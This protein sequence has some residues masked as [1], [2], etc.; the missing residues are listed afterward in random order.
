M[1]DTLQFVVLPRSVK[2]GATRQQ[3]AITVDRIWLSALELIGFN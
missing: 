2:V 3:T 1:S